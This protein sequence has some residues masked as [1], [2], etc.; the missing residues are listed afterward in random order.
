M[1]EWKIDP[2]IPDITNTAPKIDTALESNKNSSASV[3]TVAAIAPYIAKV[4]ENE[5]VSNMKFGLDK[6]IL[7]F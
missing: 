4:R 1:I 6:R 3:P 5:K 7:K 2:I